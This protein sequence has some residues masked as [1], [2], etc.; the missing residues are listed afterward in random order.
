M[1]LPAIEEG[2]LP[3]RQASTPAEVAEER[4][5]L[6][7]GLTR[8]RV[9]LWLSWAARRPISSRNP[10]IPASS[11]TRS[12]MPSRVIRLACRWRAS[13]PSGSSSRRN[14]NRSNQ[15][16]SRAS[17]SPPPAARAV[18]ERSTPMARSTSVRRKNSSPLTW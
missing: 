18:R 1:L 3:I 17:T 7:V 13:S 12:A 15:I 14:P 2:V 11:P 6:Y 5:L 8:A 10:A 9:H 4:R 16:A